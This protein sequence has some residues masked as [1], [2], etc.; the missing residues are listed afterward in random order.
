[1]KKNKG[2]TIIALVITIIV[3][4]ILTG[5][6]VALLI[7][8]NGLIA[9]AITA[10][11]KTEEAKL[12]E[13]D[14]LATTNKMMDKYVTNR[15]GSITIDSDT[16]NQMIET[17]VNEKMYSPTIFHGNVVTNTMGAT[18]TSTHANTFTVPESG[19]YVL[20]YYGELHWNASSVFGVSMYKG[21][22]RIAY[23]VYSNNLE[24]SVAGL[25]LTSIQELNQGDVIQVYIYQYNNGS[26]GANNLTTN[27][28]QL[29]K[30]GN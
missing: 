18:N 9:K 10:R 15:D 2:I 6:S 27:D 23:N 19:K 28:L 26:A 16:L 5:V 20:N 14:K 1:M 29:I 8:E 21:S 25:N 13:E 12:D 4:L 11:D 17:K 7:G 24:Y 22:T 3:L 30:V